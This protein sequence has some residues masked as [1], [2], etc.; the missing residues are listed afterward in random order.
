MSGA[1]GERVHGANRACALQP[2]DLAPGPA[3]MFVRHMVLGQ[4]S[5]VTYI[6]GT[7]RVPSKSS[8]PH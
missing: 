3:L 8:T 1:G 4:V 7:G 6:L 2:G 5:K